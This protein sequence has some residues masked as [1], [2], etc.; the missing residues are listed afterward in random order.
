MDNIFKKIGVDC[1]Y[2]HLLVDGSKY[3]IFTKL[4]TCLKNLNL[5]VCNGYEIH[6][7]EFTVDNI[8]EFA[9]N[10]GCQSQEKYL[11]QIKSAILSGNVI[12]SEISENIL[13]RFG[14]DSS[15]ISS[16]LLPCTSVMR[17]ELFHFIFFEIAGKLDQAHN[18]LSKVQDPVEQSIDSSIS[19]GTTSSSSNNLGLFHFDRN[20]NKSKQS[21]PRKPGESIINPGTRKRKKATGVI[22]D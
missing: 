4:S 3:V 21:R 18:D 7:I 11:S 8:D 2:K 13:L 10:T 6:T 1:L 19:F 17:K 22:F 9:H 16:T 20:S 12:V 5:C 14:I 15:A